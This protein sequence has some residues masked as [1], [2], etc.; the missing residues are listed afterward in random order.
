MSIEHYYVLDLILAAF[1]HAYLP[2]LQELCEVNII[3]IAISQVRK[4]RI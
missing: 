3:D 1:R 2:S 4:Q